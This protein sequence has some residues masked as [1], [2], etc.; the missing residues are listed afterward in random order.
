LG[1]H[2]GVKG[3]NPFLFTKN[4]ID[5]LL[6]RLNGYKDEAGTVVKPEESDALIKAIKA[7]NPEHDP[8]VTNVEPD[9]KLAQGTT[10]VMTTGGVLTKEDA[11]RKNAVVI[12]PNQPK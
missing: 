12:Q 9:A 11:A 3:R 8:I 5:P 1:K 6:K 10:L 2:I 7:L 4:V